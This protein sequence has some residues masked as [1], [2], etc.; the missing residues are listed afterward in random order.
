MVHFFFFKN[1]NLGILSQ[2]TY[3]LANSAVEYVINDPQ[4]LF[5]VIG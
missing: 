2:A 4:M 5:R 1:K 3:D